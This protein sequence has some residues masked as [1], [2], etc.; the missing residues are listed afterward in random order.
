MRPGVL[1]P[2]TR[3]L[4]SGRSWASD[5]CSRKVASSAF[6][7]SAMTSP[8]HVAGSE[9]DR[10]GSGP[11][12]PPHR[13]SRRKH[14]VGGLGVE[15]DVADF[16]DDDQGDEPKPPQLGPLRAFAV[17]RV[18]PGLCCRGSTPGSGASLATSGCRLLG[19]P[20]PHGAAQ[21]SRTKSPKAPPRWY[22]ADALAINSWVRVVRLVALVVGMLALTSATAAA[23]PGGATVFTHSAKSGELRGGRLTLRSVSRRVTA[24]TN[25]G[26][27]GVVSV[28]RLHAR[29]FGSGVAP[30]TGTL[31]VAGDRGG[32]EST[33]S[34]SRAR[35]SASRHTVSYAAKPL[36]QRS[37][38]SR[39]ARAAQNGAAQ[40]FGAASLSIVPSPQVTLGDNG[41]LDCSTT[42]TNNTS[43]LL[44]AAA[45]PNWPTDTWNPGIPFQAQLTA[46]GTGTI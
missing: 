42:L 13:Q 20:F 37:L 28:T 35:Y 16:V 45:E 39:G 11:A 29:L 40:Q 32:D 15:R 43:H 38:P 2:A 14:H 22:A 3:T 7:R 10:S 18:P 12:P 17:V 25:A 5:G 44:E 46:L 34:L 21:R 36:N 6:S 30:A 26:H 31:H 1:K 41:G 24:V 9:R 27:S 4:P 23:T 33:F 19:R 8:S